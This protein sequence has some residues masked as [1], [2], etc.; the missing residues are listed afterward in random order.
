MEKRAIFGLT[1][2]SELPELNEGEFYVQVKSNGDIRYMRG[3]DADEAEYD[4]VKSGFD[5]D[6]IIVCN[7]AQYD[8][9]CE[10]SRYKIAC[11]QASGK[12]FKEACEI[13]F[14]RA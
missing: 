5:T 2:T 4:L 11:L 14:E 10:A 9:L 1:E 6:K 12:T 8:K 3:W 7:N 13:V